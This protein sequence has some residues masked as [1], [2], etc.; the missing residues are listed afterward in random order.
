M[1]A[2][3]CSLYLEEE[4]GNNQNRGMK[5]ER[6]QGKDEHRDDSDPVVEVDA[7]ELILQVL[8]KR[9]SNLDLDLVLERVTMVSRHLSTAVDVDEPVRRE[10]VRRVPDLSRFRRHVG[11]VLEFSVVEHATREDADVG[12]HSVLDAGRRRERGGQS[13]ARCVCWREGTRELTREGER[14]EAISS[15]FERTSTPSSCT[16]RR[17]ET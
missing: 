11:T 17:L 6:S 2:I 13:I 8:V 4:E 7:R 3:F 5:I 12:V 15:G 9:E 14:C 16:S 1:R 10:G